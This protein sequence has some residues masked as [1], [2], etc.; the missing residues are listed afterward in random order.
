MEELAAVNDHGLARDEVGRRLHGKPTAPATS[1]GTW[2]RWIVL[3]ATDASH[4]SVDD[5]RVR[6]H[7]LR[8]R[9]PGGDA[10]HMDPVPPELLRERAGQRD[11]RA[12]LVT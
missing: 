3:A 2:S 8:H 10:V 12:F 7:A 1:S 11:D 9:E 6:L 4:S 5:L